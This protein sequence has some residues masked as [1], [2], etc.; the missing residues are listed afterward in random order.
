LEFFLV[1]TSIRVL[2]QSLL[3]VGFLDLVHR[4]SL[5]YAKQ[6]VELGVVDLLWRA[7]RLATHLLY[8]EMLDSVKT[9]ASANLWFCV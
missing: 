1:A 8:S 3:S 4:G 2:F 7:T 6:L 5:L 9:R